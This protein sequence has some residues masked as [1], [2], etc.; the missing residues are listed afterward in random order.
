MDPLVSTLSIKEF[1]I[2]RNSVKVEKKITKTFRSMKGKKILESHKNSM[3]KKRT[4]R[5]LKKRGEVRGRK[6]FKIMNRE[7]S[8]V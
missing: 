5:R 4:E 3:R 7:E 8:Q 2:G 6:M 1:L